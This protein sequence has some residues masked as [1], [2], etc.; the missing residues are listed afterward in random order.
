MLK[1]LLFLAVYLHVRI[2]CLQ[3]PRQFSEINHNY[4]FNKLPSRTHN[5]IKNVNNNIIFTWVN[6]TNVLLIEIIYNSTAKPQH[7]QTRSPK[8]EAVPVRILQ[9]T[10]KSQNWTIT[11][12]DL[13]PRCALRHVLGFACER[14]H[15]GH[16]GVRLWRG[17]VRGG[18]QELQ[19]AAGYAAIV[20]GT[21]RRALACRWQVR[22]YYHYSLSWPQTT[23]KT[24]HHVVSPQG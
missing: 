10:N 14:D 5:L 20:R 1:Y 18:P 22:Y 15:H 19:P 4:V 3:Y 13:V 8:E 24:H 7:S 12:I 9:P 23:F 17:G 11:L 6:V 21:G 2:L 16:Q